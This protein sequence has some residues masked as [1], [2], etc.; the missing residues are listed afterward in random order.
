MEDGFASSF[1][2]NLPKNLEALHTRNP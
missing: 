1:N 2:L